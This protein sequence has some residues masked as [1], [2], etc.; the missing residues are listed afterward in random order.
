MREDIL[1]G[2]A[3]GRL[4]LRKRKI[5]PMSD[6]LKKLLLALF[7]WVMLNRYIPDGLFFGVLIILLLSLLIELTVKVKE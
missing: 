6:L 5:E 3:V 7:V 1:F 4:H 2:L